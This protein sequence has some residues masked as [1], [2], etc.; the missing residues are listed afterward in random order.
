[1]LKDDD[2]FEAMKDLV[3]FKSASG[4]YVTVEEYKARN[5]SEDKKTKIWYDASEDTKV[6]YLKMMK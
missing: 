3:I 6:S 2:L 1:M 4:D 5:Q